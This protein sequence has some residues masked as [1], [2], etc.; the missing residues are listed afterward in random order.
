MN[1]IKLGDKVIVGPKTKAL[2][3]GIVEKTH[4]TVSAVF[5]HVKITKICD[6]ASVYRVGNLIPCYYRDLTVVTEP[7]DIM[8]EII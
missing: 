6:K 3:Y 8:K 5:Y 7:N 4:I 2:Y 1:D